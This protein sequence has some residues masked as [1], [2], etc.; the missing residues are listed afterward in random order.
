MDLIKSVFFIPEGETLLGDED[1]QYKDGIVT[2][3]QTKSFAFRSFNIAQKT[4][5]RWRG[6][7]FIIKTMQIIK[8][9]LRSS[10]MQK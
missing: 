3:F 1:C 5:G 2:I 8:N 7:F 10:R 6:F 4:I 9:D